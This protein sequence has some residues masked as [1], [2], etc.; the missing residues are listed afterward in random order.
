MRRQYKQSQ[1]NGENFE[2]SSGR[3]HKYFHRSAL[4][5]SQATTDLREIW[6]AHAFCVLVKAL[7]LHELLSNR[8]EALM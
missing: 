5:H 8:R 3:V 1:Y 4:L 2:K 6:G 7:C